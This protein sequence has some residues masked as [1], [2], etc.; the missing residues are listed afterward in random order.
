MLAASAAKKTRKSNAVLKLAVNKYVIRG[1]YASS[2][3]IGK[4]RDCKHSMP[5]NNIKAH[6]APSHKKQYKRRGRHHT[7]RQNTA[8]HDGTPQET[9]GR[10][11]KQSQHKT[12]HSAETHSINLSSKWQLAGDSLDNIKFTLQFAM[13]P[14]Q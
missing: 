12:N 8:R 13:K 2:R 5:K 1:S 10:R 9:A 6:S 14:K 7:T 11:P 3:L 4:L